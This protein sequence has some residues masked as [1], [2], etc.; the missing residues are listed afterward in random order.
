MESNDGTEM[1]ILKLERRPRD[2]V[3]YRTTAWLT[4]P[5]AAAAAA[6]EEEEDVDVEEAVD[7]DDS[8]AG[9]PGFF[10]SLAARSADCLRRNDRPRRD[11]RWATTW[12]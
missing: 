8:L 5:A 12:V 1:E 4:A 2:A 9:S 7:D 6:V 11:R 10:G 3:P